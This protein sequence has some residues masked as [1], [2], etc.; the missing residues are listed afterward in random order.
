MPVLGIQK[1]KSRLWYI[2]IFQAYVKHWYSLTAMTFDF[3]AT[4]CVEMS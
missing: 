1:L 4:C 3:L 2:N